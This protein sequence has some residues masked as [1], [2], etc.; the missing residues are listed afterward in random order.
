MDPT[1][2]PNDIPTN[3]PVIEPTVSERSPLFE[4]RAWRRE[5]DRMIPE[6][7][8][9]AAAMER[10]MEARREV[11]EWIRARERKA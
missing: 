8:D 3:M 2:M 4:M 6:F 5:L 1:N 7:A 9:N 10:I 11:D